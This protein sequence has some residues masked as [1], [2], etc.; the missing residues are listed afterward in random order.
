[1]QRHL[2][3]LTSDRPRWSQ[4]EAVSVRRAWIVA[5]VGFAVACTDASPPTDTRAAASD[6]FRASVSGADSAWSHVSVEISIAREGPGLTARPSSSSNARIR[7]EKWLEQDGWRTRVVFLQA[8]RTRADSATISSVVFDPNGSVAGA[9]DAYGRAVA[10]VSHDGPRLSVDHVR[11][12][13]AALGG[14]QRSSM[15][16]PTSVR[17]VATPAMGPLA[18]AT[19]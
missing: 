2:P 8:L 5:A 6:E 7:L 12:M 4:C 3:W 17:R 11:A 15:A 19:K 16:V 10:I 18:N 13:I 14:T 1:M 9:Y